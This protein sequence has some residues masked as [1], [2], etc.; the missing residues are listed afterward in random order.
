MSTAGDNASA[1]PGRLLRMTLQVYANTKNKPED[2]EAFAREYHAKVAS[3][4]ARNGIEAYQQVFTPPPYRAALD[5]MNRARNRGWVVDDHDLTAEFYF[6]NFAE[7]EKVRADPDFQA[8]Q[9]AEGPYVNLVHTVVS[10]GWVE[11]YVDAGKVVNIGEDGKSM[12]PP[13]KE[14]M[15]LSTARGPVEAGK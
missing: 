11:K 7:L 5:E 14:L 3:I 6:R 15:D 9:A 13:W 1:F 10:L 12:Y 8:L 4:H 2:N